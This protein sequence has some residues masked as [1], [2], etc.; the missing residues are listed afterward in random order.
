MELCVLA[1]KPG[2]QRVDLAEDVA[3]LAFDARD[4]A[5]WKTRRTMP[6]HTDPQAE[7]REELC[8]AVRDFGQV[9]HRLINTPGVDWHQLPIA[10]ATLVGQSSQSKVRVTARFHIA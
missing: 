10:R 1:M 9:P 3:Q 8:V 7:L 5:D 2:E 6:R 4:L